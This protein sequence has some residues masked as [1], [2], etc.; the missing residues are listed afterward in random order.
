MNI[1]RIV[2]FCLH[3]KNED[4]WYR[5]RSQKNFKNSILPLD[6]RWDLFHH[7]VGRN[8]STKLDI[9]H[10]TKDVSN[11]CGCQLPLFQW[12]KH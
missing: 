3:K 10:I 1:T 12:Q 6:D 4:V 2:K 5:M 7:M 9:F 11:E 8:I